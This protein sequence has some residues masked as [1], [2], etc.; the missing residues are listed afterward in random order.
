VAAPDPLAPLAQ[1]PGVADAGEEAREALALA[2]RHKSNRRGWPA[3]A[4]ESAM[5]A[6]RASS[7]LDGGSLVLNPDDERDPILAGAL[8]VA[9][10]L[11]GGATSLIGV[12]Q[13]APL[14]AIARL[15]ALAAVD[16]TDDDRLGRPRADPGVG[17]RLET[18]AD[19][20]TSTRVPAPVLAA[21]VHG[22]LLTLAPF[23]V[24]DGVVARGVSRLAT[25]ASGLD[26]HGL[27][28]PELFW[29]QKSGDYRT[30]ARGFESGT[31]EGLAAWLINSGKALKAGARE[32]LAI[33]EAAAK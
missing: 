33:A 21:V 17:R 9:E 19:V 15:H 28:V 5:R 4:A 16:L 22:E 13:R 7:V 12:W 27:G 20:V 6:A 11:E 30:A 31:P 1:L 18:L 29:M 32:A 24:A 3:T 10:A 23:G 26:T 8:R 14:Q 2:A 25:I